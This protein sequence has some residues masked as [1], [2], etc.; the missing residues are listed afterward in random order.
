MDNGSDAKRA[1][2]ARLGIVLSAS[3][4]AGC[5]TFLVPLGLGSGSAIVSWERPTR[6]ANGTALR[7]LAGYDLYYGRNPSA[8]THQV[9]IASP[10]KTRCVVRGLRSGT[11][12][13]VVTAYTSGGTQSV[14]SNV[15]SKTIP[16]AL[17]AGRSAEGGQ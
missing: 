11:W 3:V 7:N 9:Q 6:T 8:L 17:D 16:G 4:F 5:A 2:V 15:L 10:A 13:F 14:P 12:Y 1:R